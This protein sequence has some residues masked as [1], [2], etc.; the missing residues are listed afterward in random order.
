[1]T[2]KVGIEKTSLYPA[3]VDCTGTVWFV[4]RDE[5]RHRGFYGRENSIPDYRGCVGYSSDDKWFL[6][7]DSDDTVP[8]G[9]IVGLVVDPNG[10]R[11]FGTWGNGLFRNCGNSWT[12]FDTLNSDLPTMFSNPIAVDGAGRV[13]TALHKKPR[14]SGGNGY[15][16]AYETPEPAGV[17]SFDGETFRHYRR[18]NSGLPD[19]L[20]SCADS[21]PSGNIWFGTHKGL[22]V[23]NPDGIQEGDLPGADIN[24]DRLPFADD[25][26][27]CRIVQKKGRLFLDLRIPGIRQARVE[28]FTLS[29]RRVAHVVT[30]PQSGRR[31]QIEPIGAHRLTPGNYVRRIRLTDSA[32]RITL[33]TG[34][35]TVGF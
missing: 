6:L 7:R 28:L 12:V 22:A 30:S 3:A 23:F 26:A 24:D 8:A 35:V 27:V 34:T 15:L 14:N 11:W 1:M 18:T 33:S 9:Q 16:S 19:D 17:C 4:T 10:C 5:H 21:D 25:K 20:V 31:T 13:W 32:G 29:G 2:E